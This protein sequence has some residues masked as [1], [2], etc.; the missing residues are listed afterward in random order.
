MSVGPVATRTATTTPRDRWF[1]DGELEVQRR[2]GLSEEAARLEGMMVPTTGFS[3]GMRTVLGQRRSA[4]L[5]ASDAAGRLWCSPLIGPEGFLD[6]RGTWL[7]IHAEP[8]RD[9][10]LHQMEAGQ[11]VGV[12]S[13]D[14]ATR[15]RLRM[16]GHLVARDKGTLLVDVEQAYGNCPAYI[17][18][19]VVEFDAKQ[20]ES[21]AEIGDLTRRST[22][23]SQEDVATIAAADTFFVGSRHGSAGADASHKGGRPGFVRS[24][25]DVVWWP[26]Y[27]G[28]NMF[29]TLG[30]IA[31]S[32][33]TA[34][35]FLDFA[36]RRVVQISGRARI[37]WIEPGSAGD[38]GDTGR[39]VRV[40][41]EQVVSRP[42]LGMVSLEGPGA[43]DTPRLK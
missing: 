35:L 17:H 7:G 22:S 15:R 34:L 21:P 25:G 4:V 23:L 33:A 3:R 40:E 42:V 9:D 16:N 30:N 8:D 11:D 10:P 5:T 26:D 32:P 31:A 43:G 20:G 38:D 37:E 28:N 18:E 1:H 27:A 39:R 41:V 14:F 13:V 6:A 36:R 29:N 19:R 2:A 12:L 24:D